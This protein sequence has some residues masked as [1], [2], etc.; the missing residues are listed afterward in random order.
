M[1]GFFKKSHILFFLKNG[2]LQKILGI[3]FTIHSK[4][5]TILLKSFHAIFSKR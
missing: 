5:L 1:V 3:V 2:S 4:V